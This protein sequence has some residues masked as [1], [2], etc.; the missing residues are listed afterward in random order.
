[1]KILF[2]RPVPQLGEGY[3]GFHQGVGYI[4][5]VL[6][7]AGHRTALLEPDKF[8]S[9]SVSKSIA[10]FKPDVVAL[11]VT[12]NQTRLSGRIAE[13]VSQ[14]HGKPVILGGAHPTVAPEESI[15]LKG[16]FGLCIGEG[17]YPML[18]LADA[19]EAGKDYMAISNFW[20][21]KDGRVVKNDIR[22]LIGDLDSLPFP[23]RE[24]YDYQ[25][26]ID[27]VDLGA[28][29]MGSRGCPKNC[30]YCINSTLRGLFKDKGRYVRYRS[31]DNLLSEIESVRSKYSNVNYIGFHDDTFTVNRGWLEEFCHKYSKRI[32]LPF[33][34]NARVD[35]V[36]K[37]TVELLKKAGC[38]RVH[39]GIESG[40]DYIRQKILKRNITKAQIAE[41]FRLFKE[42]GIE[43]S[44]F[45]MIGLP[46]EKAEMIEETIS[47][48]RLVKPDYAFI[49]LFY[50]YPGT[51]LR[52]LCQENGW[53]SER[54]VESY[55]EPTT[56]LDQPSISSQ[57]VEYYYKVFQP[58]IHH[59]AYDGLIRMLGGI[60]IWSR[61]TLLD[62]IRT[63]RSL[64][65]TCLRK[66]C[67]V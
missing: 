37:N 35:S 36:D 67:S 51:E 13:F 63:I 47:L 8:D 58:L 17:E 2:I 31:V 66:K 12:S 1:M 33:W 43:T 46:C 3:N 52:K 27:V 26:M 49:S 38:R 4:S 55:F 29:F 62:M 7:R 32:K 22:P 48:N 14:K 65:F 61:I 18:E 15:S 50:P 24:V 44:A 57:E 25:K 54:F 60:K 59:P 16:V 10:G 53:I 28:E 19:L 41:C 5:A 64:A 20:F 39:I 6:K 21:N 34:C 30:P 40:N 45:N 11:S 9:H 42:A 23:D 56:V